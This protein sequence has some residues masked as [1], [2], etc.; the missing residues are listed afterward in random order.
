MSQKVG[1]RSRPVLLRDAEN[2]Q[3]ERRAG[4]TKA[5]ANKSSKVPPSGLSMGTRATCAVSEEKVL[6][7]LLPV[8]LAKRATLVY[9]CCMRS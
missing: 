4:A 6:Q 8:T 5:S 7:S 3:S 9:T 1:F 2:V